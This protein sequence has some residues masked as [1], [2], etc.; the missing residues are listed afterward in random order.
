MFMKFNNYILQAI[1]KNARLK[2]FLK[3][4]ERK[5]KE[6][7]KKHKLVK[8]LIALSL[9]KKEDMQTG[10]LS[11]KAEFLNQYPNDSKSFLAYYESQ[12]LNGSERF[13]VY[14][15]K[16]R[17]NNVLESN[18]RS[19]NASLKENRRNKQFFSKFTF[20]LLY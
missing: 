17:T 18:H 14:R 8:K 13:S 5:K 19:L 16:V 2:G 6:A 7:P 10:Y 20:Y 15:C 11:I 4:Q 3:K 9:L 1:Y 12:W